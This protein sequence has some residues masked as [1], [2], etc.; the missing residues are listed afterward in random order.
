MTDTKN[1]IT[2][3]EARQELVRRELVRRR[4]FGY[5][6]VEEPAEQDS[7]APSDAPLSP[8]RPL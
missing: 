3:V 7:A 4:V 1:G 2:A 6:V 8:S 5:T